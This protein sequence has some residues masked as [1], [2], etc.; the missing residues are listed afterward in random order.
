[1]PLE[2]PGSARKSA[3]VVIAG[4]AGRLGNRLFQS[5]HFM[6]NALNRGYRLLNPSL[7][8][9]A[10]CF[11][12]SAR[13]PLCGF[14]EA[15]AEQD[16]EFSAQCRE[17]FF[18]AAHV[19]G[20]ASSLMRLKG[21]RG[22]DIRLSDEAE[23]GGVD[24]NGSDFGKLLDE[25]RYILPMGWKFSDHTAM[26]LHREKI[27]RYFTPV[28]SVRKPAQDTLVRAREL[29]RRVIGVHIRQED[30]RN[31]K[32]GVYYFDTERYVRWMRESEECFGGEKVSFVV[33][34]SDRL[35]FRVFE[36][37]KW[38]P[39]PGFPVGDLHALSLCD[40]IMG[41]PSTFSEWASYHGDVPLCVLKN[42]TQVINRTDF[43]R[44]FGPR[45]PLLV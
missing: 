9:Y 43:L 8:E 28:E 45:N 21:V 15:W 13:D 34:S 10:P 2:Y 29:G 25:F 31:W 17:L 30:Y 1:M 12:G 5:A 19:I 22:I 20:I 27:S 44:P 24:L 11:E 18:G 16:P 42:G 37:L 6:G 7:G 26:I 35:D 23:G 38:V 33:C 32:Q 39:G 36:G 41:P 3:T 40:M 4:K 14:P